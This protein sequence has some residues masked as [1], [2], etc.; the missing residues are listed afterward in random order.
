[1]N[2]E[3]GGLRVALTFDAEH[4]DRP[5]CPQGN[6]ERILGTLRDR[7]VR[8]TFFLQGRW[9]EAYPDTARR[10]A[11]DGH[12]V[13]NHSHHHARMPLLN[14]EGLSSDVRQ[15]QEAVMAATGVDPR[16]WFR[17][18]FG[19]G[20]DDPRVLGALEAQ[21]YRNVFWHVE[22]QDWEAWRSGDAISADG[23]EGVQRHGDGAVVLLH[24]WPGGTGDAIGPMI[25]GLDALDA[26]FVGV[27]Q[28]EALP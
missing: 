6:V 15:C 1:V 14:D 11:D 5:W 16:P 10:I 26:S 4:P 18:P 23:I 28:L 24:T 25:E 8:A 9:A 27:D 12:L 21:G 3:P 20:Y 22:L 13:G 19:D 7:G 17:T 2:E